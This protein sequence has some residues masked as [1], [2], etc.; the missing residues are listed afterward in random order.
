MPR[1]SGGWGPCSAPRLLGGGD[2]KAWAQANAIAGI[3]AVD[4]YLARAAYWE[5]KRNRQRADAEYRAATERIDALVERLRQAPPLDAFDAMIADVPPKVERAPVAPTWSATVLRNRFT[6]F[7]V[8]RIWTV[9][10]GACWEIKA[11]SCG[12][13]SRR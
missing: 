2:E 4:G 1:H 3:D 13:L 10:P 9:A 5:A 12:T 8:R 7:G 6:A 11:L